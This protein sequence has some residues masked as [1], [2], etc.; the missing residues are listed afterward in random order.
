MVVRFFGS[1]YQAG[2]LKGESGDDVAR[3]SNVLLAERAGVRPGMRIWDAG[4]GSGGPAIDVAR[5]Y[6]GVTI[7]GTN[8]SASQ[9]AAATEFARQAGVE[10]RVHFRVADYHE[11]PF[12][13]ASFDAVLF[14]E[15]TSYS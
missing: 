7:E 14:F 1:T 6:E 15:C 8:V 10:D 9:V 13:E 5:T 3:R 4:C 11:P 2:L 12:E